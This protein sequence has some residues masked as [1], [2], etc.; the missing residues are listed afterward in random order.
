MSGEDEVLDAITTL[1]V[2]GYRGVQLKADAA[3]HWLWVSEDEGPETAAA[4]TQIIFRI[5]PGAVQI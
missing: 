2:H 1:A 5:D 3:S 4:I